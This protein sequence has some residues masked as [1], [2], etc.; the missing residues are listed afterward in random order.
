MSFEP[1]PVYFIL[2][3]A[4]SSHPKDLRYTWSLHGRHSRCGT[5]IVDAML[6]HLN[7]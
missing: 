4:K 2:F 3:F 7:I 5:W 1:N 6:K